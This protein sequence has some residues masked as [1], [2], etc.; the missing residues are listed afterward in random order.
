MDKEYDHDPANAN[1]LFSRADVMNVVNMFFTDDFVNVSLRGRRDHLM[2][3][4]HPLPLDSELMTLNDVRILS[5]WH[6]IISEG[7]I[8]EDN[9]GGHLVGPHGPLGPSPGPGPGPLAGSE[10][11]PG[12]T[13][14]GSSPL[15]KAW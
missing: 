5:S 4:V 13:R 2:H 9:L 8:S 6:S 10:A 7:A 1:A 3:Q 15:A 14:M 11:A 12:L